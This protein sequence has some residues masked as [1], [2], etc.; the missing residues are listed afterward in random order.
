MKKNLGNLILAVLIFFSTQ[1]LASEYKWKAFVNKNTAFVNEAIHLSYVCEFSDRAELYSIDFNPVKSYE[2]YD[3]VLLTEGIKI[4]NNKKINFYEFIAFVKSSG[5][6]DFTFDALMKKT[7]QGSIENTVLGRDNV[8]N[9][10]FTSK[11]VKQNT[12]SVDVKGSPSDLIGNFSLEIKKDKGKKK[13]YEPYHLEIIIKGVGNFQVLKP[14]EFNID[15]VKVFA[16]KIIDKT[17][18]TKDGYSG[19]WSQKFAFV[20]ENGFEIPQVK[21]RYTDSTDASEKEL[22][23]DSI[24]VEVLEGYK[25]EELID[26]EE[27]KFEFSYDFIYYILTFI[28]GFLFAKIKFKKDKGLNERTVYFREKINNAKSLDELS[29]LLILEDSIKYK[30]IINDIESSNIKSFKSV[31]KSILLI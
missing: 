18:L 10:Q 8:Q 29:M 28:A 26:K 3:L 16:Q 17:V 20:G 11:I 15:N 12:L 14:F 2:K 7:T 6:V 27:E 31:K 13:A 1:L 4:I 25:K 30:K 24:K 23:L 9:E 5:K 19:Q 21:I 22:I